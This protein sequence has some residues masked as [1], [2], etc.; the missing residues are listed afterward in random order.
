MFT[1][2]IKFCDGFALLIHLAHNLRLF[3]TINV[4]IMRTSFPVLQAYNYLCSVTSIILYSDL[5]IYISKNS[6]ILYF[7]LD[8]N[9]YF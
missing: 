8:N 7:F 4:Y 6:T 3:P 1:N 5:N 2:V 9:Q